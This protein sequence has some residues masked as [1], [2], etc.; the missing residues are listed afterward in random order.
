MIGLYVGLKG[1]KLKD[2]KNKKEALLEILEIY[3]HSLM[4]RA[5]DMKSKN[6][7][8]KLTSEQSE[9]LR[10]FAVEKALDYV[11]RNYG[12]VSKYFTRE[13]IN[14]L[15]SKMVE[16]LKQSNPVDYEAIAEAVAYKLFVEGPGGEDEEEDV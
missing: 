12:N 11:N 4:D 1:L 9:A 8:G 13:D 15:V 7:S 3:V 5:A 2:L 16:K 6:E 14:A 10:A